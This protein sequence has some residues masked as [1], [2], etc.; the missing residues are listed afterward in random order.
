[1]PARLVA[2]SHYETFRNLEESLWRTETRFNKE[3]MNRILAPGFFEFGRSGRI[4]SREEILAAPPQ[5]INARLPLK[6][7]KVHPISADIVLVTYQ[8][9]VTYDNLEISNRSSLWQK[10]PAGWQLQFHQGTPVS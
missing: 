6:D 4:Y 8:S 10:T 3:Y 5:E 2:E 1:M 7:F 9:E